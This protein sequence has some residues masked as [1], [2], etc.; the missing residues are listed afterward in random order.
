MPLP[1][2][3]FFSVWMGLPR[4]R[5]VSPTRDGVDW[6]A[7]EQQGGGGGGG[8]GDGSKASVLPA[9]QAMVPPSSM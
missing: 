5:S 4:S 6:R 9:R 1:L 3:P 8:G 2:L 7:G